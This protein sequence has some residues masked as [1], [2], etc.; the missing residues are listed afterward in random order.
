MLKS[1]KEKYASAAHVVHAF[2]L[3]DDGG[4]CGCSDDG[5]PSG[6]AGRPVL[7]VLRGSAVTGC[8]ITVTR[9]FGGTLLG[10]GGLVKAYGSAAKAVLALVETRECAHRLQFSLKLPYDAFGWFKRYAEDAGIELT[11]R[12]FG[13][14]VFLEG[15]VPEGGADAFSAAVSNHTSGWSAPEF[16]GK[17]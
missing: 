16:L 2:A 7:E 6:T 17:G 11:A 9:W 14:S 12:T 15:C 4:I 3:G 8:M 5:E 13:D 1:Q 10:T